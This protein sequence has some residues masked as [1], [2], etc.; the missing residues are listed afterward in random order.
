MAMIYDLGDFAAKVILADPEFTKM[1]ADLASLTR[2]DGTFFENLDPY[3]ILRL[4]CENAANLDENVSTT[5]LKIRRFDGRVSIANSIHTRA[6]S[7]ERRNT[8]EHSSNPEAKAKIRRMISPSCHTL[9]ITFSRN[10]RR[11]ER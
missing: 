6:S 11:S 3:V 2:H 8:P 9:G 7:S 5:S 1:E 4:L 10:V